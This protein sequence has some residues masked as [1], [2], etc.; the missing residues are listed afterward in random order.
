MVDSSSSALVEY[1][2]GGIRVWDKKYHLCTEIRSIKLLSS[3]SY[4]RICM[5]SVTIIYLCFHWEKERKKEERLWIVLVKE[6][7]SK[8]QCPCHIHTRYEWVLLLQGC[9]QKLSK[10]WP[11]LYE[12]SVCCFV[13]GVNA[14]NQNVIE[15]C[16]KSQKKCIDESQNN[17]AVHHRIKEWREKAIRLTVLMNLQVVDIVLPC[18]ALHCKE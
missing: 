10:I 8:L 5:I 17:K 2:V 6:I 11:F 16:S 4:Q 18:F 7:K 3:T 15:T 9:S 14:W 12:S 13:L 1:E